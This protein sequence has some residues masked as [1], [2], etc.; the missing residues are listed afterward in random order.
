MGKINGPYSADYPVGSKVRIKSI[1]ML[2]E[3]QRVWKLHNPLKEEQLQYAGCLCEVSKV[4]YYHG[5]DELYTLKD[6]PGLWHCCC[7]ESE[8]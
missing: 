7:I 1:S 4:G 5:G 6:I 3:F 2:Q 8:T